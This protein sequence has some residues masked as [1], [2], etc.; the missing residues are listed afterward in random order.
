MRRLLRTLLLPA[1]LFAIAPIVGAPLAA[2]PSPALGP[3]DGK[4]LAPTDIERV[5]VGQPAPD[6]SLARYGGGTLTLSQFRGRKNVVLVFYR[7]HWCPYCITQLRELRTLLDAELRKEAEL[8][9]VSLDGDAETRMAVARIASDG[10]QPDFTF[11]SDPEH[12]VID[13]YGVLNPS[14]SRR[15]I[16][17]PAAYVIDT[18]GIVRWRDVQTDYKVRPTNAAILT[19]LQQVNR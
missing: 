13:R 8:L 6:F 7:G 9:V 2:Q 4:N 14:G 10:V 3:V 17:H 16:P 1:A 11:L 18:Q 5:A 19:A 15:G 12:A